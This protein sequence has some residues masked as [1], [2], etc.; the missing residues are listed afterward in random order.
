[1]CQVSLLSL[2]VFTYFT[3]HN[4]GSNSMK[5]VLVSPFDGWK[6]A[7]GPER[8]STLSHVTQPGSGSQN[9]TAHSNYCYSSFKSVPGTGLC[10]FTEFS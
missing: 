9:D 2:Y 8:L 3:S 5:E 7:W 6:I 10:T 1:M 4:L